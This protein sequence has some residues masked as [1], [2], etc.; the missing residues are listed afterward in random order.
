M[1]K[2]R[3]HASEAEPTPASLAI[4]MRS[5]FAA[6]KRSQLRAVAEERKTPA[7]AI[8]SLERLY[9]RLT[10]AY[11]G[12]DGTTYADW[13]EHGPRA[14]LEEVREARRDDAVWDRLVDRAV[15]EVVDMRGVR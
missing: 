13:L 12:A 7:Q 3:E 4:S 14:E 8:T 9:N 5:R 10:S 15:A 6:Y 1:G 2:R 11:L